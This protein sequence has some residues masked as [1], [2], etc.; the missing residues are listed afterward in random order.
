MILTVIVAQIPITKLI[1]P[2]NVFLRTPFILIHLILVHNEYSHVFYV[3]LM[4]P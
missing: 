2:F 4:D 1:K 3:I